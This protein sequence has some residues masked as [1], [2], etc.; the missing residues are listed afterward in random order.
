MCHRAR[1]PFSH[2]TTVFFFFFLSSRF[3]LNVYYWYNIICA[4]RPSESEMERYFKR[5]YI[6]YFDFFCT[7]FAICEATNTAGQHDKS[8]FGVEF[9]FFTLLDLIEKSSKIARRWGEKN[10]VWSAIVMG[11]FTFCFGWT[12]SLFFH[13]LPIFVYLFTVLSLSLSVLIIHGI[14]DDRRMVMERSVTLSACD[15][16]HIRV[17]GTAANENWWLCQTIWRHS[18][19]LDNVQIARTILARCAQF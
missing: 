10:D 13:M 4:E 2:C 14:Q 8:N 11:L 12:F 16:S 3:C 6:F 15:C 5:N 9:T 1:W 19:R 18:N 17:D 7:P